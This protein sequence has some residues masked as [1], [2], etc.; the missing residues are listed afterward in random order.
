MNRLDYKLIKALAAV[1]Q[2]QS[3]ERASKVLFITQ[4]AVSQRIK[5]LEREMGQPVLIRQIPFSATDVGKKLLKHFYQV[6]HLEKNLEKEVFPDTNLTK[7]TVHI[8]V[9]SDSLATWFWPSLSDVLKENLV[10][11]NLILSDEAHTI[12]K[13]KSG[14]VFGAVTLQKEAEKGFQ[15]DLLGTFRYALVA[16][17]E[18]VNRH[19]HDG[20]TREA[21]KRAPSAAFDQRDSMHINLIKEHYGLLEGEYPLH[22]IRS[23]EAFVKL[24]KS[25]VAFCLI[26]EILIQEELESGELV[27]L[28]PKFKLKK[29]LYWQRWALLQGVH[30]SISESILKKGKQLLSP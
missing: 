24:A 15:S 16:N 5:L 26:S 3:F 13:I 12:E 30:K 9:N 23:T 29:D 19:F 21:I 8:A 18:F 28:L 22:R 1:I 7:T 17:K 10:E 11:L 20:V 6:E 14:E 25:G 27:D 2:E 4:S